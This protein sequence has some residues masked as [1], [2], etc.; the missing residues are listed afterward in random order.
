MHVGV[1]VGRHVVVFAELRQ[2][3]VG[4]YWRCAQSRTG[5]GYHVVS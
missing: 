1:V 2:R 3:Y 5:Y 4:M